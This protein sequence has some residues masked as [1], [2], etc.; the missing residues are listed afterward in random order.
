MKIHSRD[1]STLTQE[2]LNEWGILKEK[3]IIHKIGKGDLAIRKSLYREY[4]VAVRH[5]MSLF[6][7]NHLD[8]EDLQKIEYLTA[9]TEKFY[10]VIDN[11]DSNERS[12]LNWIREEKA[13]FII[14]SIMK[15][16]YSFGH[17]DAF[18]FPEFQLG[19]SYQVDYLIVGKS[20]WRL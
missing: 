11:P 4:P 15:G 12:V 10:S 13:Y 7:N 1:Y 8:I 19:N 2:E 5:Y 16:S 20:F 17:H 18:I 14:A 3:E 9:L 6:P